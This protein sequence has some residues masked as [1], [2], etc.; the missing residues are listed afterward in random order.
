MFFFFN[1]KHLNKKISRKNQFLYGGWRDEKIFYQNLK[2]SQFLSHNLFL[3]CASTEVSR[4][5]YLKDYFIL[6]DHLILKLLLYLRLK[7]R[8]KFTRPR[9]WPNPTRMKARRLT[10]PKSRI[11]VKK[12]NV[13]NKKKCCFFN[14]Q[15]VSLGLRVDCNLESVSL[16]FK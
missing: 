6:R 14:Y 7:K 5:K 15:C 13:V 11:V 4:C 10:S 1:I 16:N 9:I 12:T 8:K 3:I 2:K